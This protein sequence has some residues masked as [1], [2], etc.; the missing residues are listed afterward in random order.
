MGDKYI[1]AD[2]PGDVIYDSKGKML[3]PRMWSGNDPRHI[4]FY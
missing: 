3:F 1:K 4:A 2:G